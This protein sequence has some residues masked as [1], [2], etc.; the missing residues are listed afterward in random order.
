MGIDTCQHNLHLLL[1]TA[2]SFTY[3]WLMLVN[4]AI[5]CLFSSTL[6]PFH[7][8]ICILSF[9]AQQLQ[10][11][12][13]LAWDIGRNVIANMSYYNPLLE[14]SICKTL[15]KSS[16]QYLLMQD[17]CSDISTHVCSR[18]GLYMASQSC[19]K[20]CCQ[21]LCCTQTTLCMSD[22]LFSSLKFLP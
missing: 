9:P 1:I 6:Q 14:Y 22:I 16:K 7:T 13:I 10:C 15:L 19:H 8:W 18:P 5:V 3:K 2:S 20:C 11:S 17:E 4:S 12:S 21:Q